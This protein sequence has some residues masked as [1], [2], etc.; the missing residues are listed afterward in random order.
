MSSFEIGTDEWFQELMEKRNDRDLERVR[1]LLQ[2]WVAALTESAIAYG[3]LH[4]ALVRLGRVDPA[5]AR[6]LCPVALAQDPLNGLLAPA[7]SAP[8]AKTDAPTAST[9]GYL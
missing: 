2:T 3:K 1:E 7:P 8:V 9:G 6:A 5:L 4:E